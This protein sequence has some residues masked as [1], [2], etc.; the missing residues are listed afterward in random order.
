MGP[1]KPCLGGGRGATWV[2]FTCAHRALAM[3][4]A[5]R[6]GPAC[7]GAALCWPHR[8]PGL[9]GAG[10]QRSAPPQED[11]AGQRSALREQLKQMQRERT[12]RLRALGAR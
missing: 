6:E 9:G 12:G 1:P 2:P 5:E 10:A 3:T 4:P 7:P 8:A 11:A